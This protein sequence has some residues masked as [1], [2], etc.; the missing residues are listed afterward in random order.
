MKTKIALIVAIGFALISGII[1]LSPA[2]VQAIPY[3]CPDLATCN[4]NEY[5]FYEVSH[6]GNTYQFEFDIHV[7]ATYTGNKWTDVVDSVYIK[8]LGPAL[9]SLSLVS[10]PGVVS[11]W[12]VSQHELDA[13]GFN[14]NAS[15]SNSIGAGA[16]EPSYYGAGFT[17]GGTLSWVFQ[18]N[19]TGTLNDTVTLKYLYEDTT[20]GKVGSLGS[21][22]FT[23]QVPEPTTMLLLG[24]GLIGLAGAMRKFKK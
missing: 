6:V 12:F 19:T 1:F 4:G 21:W 16:N 10:A 18:F 7:L 20:D 11:N 13:N 14:P 15:H 24:L 5:R 22:D 23:P 9:T 8:N 3:Q 17:A 2:N